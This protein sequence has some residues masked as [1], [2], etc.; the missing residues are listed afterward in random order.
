MGESRNGVSL[1]ESERYERE[2]G[3]ESELKKNGG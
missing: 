3:G 1:A 2:R